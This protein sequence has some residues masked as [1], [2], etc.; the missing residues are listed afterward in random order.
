MLFFVKS[1]LPITLVIILFYGL[2]NAAIFAS[3]EEQIEKD[4]RIDGY[5]VIP[6]D[7][8]TQQI[9]G[10]Q[11]MEARPAS[12]R[13]EFIVF[14]KAVNLQPLLVLRSQ[15][16]QALTTGNSARAKFNQSEQGVKRMQDLFRHGIAAERRLQEQQSQWQVDKSQVDAAHFQVQAIVDEARLNWGKQLTDW[17]MTV[18]PDRLDSFVSGQKTLLQIIVPSNRQL[19]DDVRTIYVEA[20]GNRSKAQEATLISIGPQID[21][22]VQGVSY[23][24]STHGKAIRTGMSVSA[25]IPDKKDSVL[26]VIIPKSALIWSMD[27]VFVYLKTGEEQFSR[28][29]IGQATPVADGY[30]IG[31]AIKPGEKVVTEGGQML[32]SEELRGQ[33]PD[34]DD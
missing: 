20:S 22:T 32:L 30:F 8:E 15:Y 21:N 4:Q 18:D 11:T 5:P 14:G 16:L 33:I 26:G 23:F 3:D 25:W 9:S 17:A 19:A 12:Y 28:R 6:L 7:Q 2:A 29:L 13:P 31:E 1:K 34:G 10:V 27:Q 24:F